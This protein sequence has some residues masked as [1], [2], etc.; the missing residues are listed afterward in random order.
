MSI[1]MAGLAVITDC[2]GA[3]IENNDQYAKHTSTHTGFHT[4]CG[5]QYVYVYVCI[6]IYVYVYVCVYV[7]VYEYMYVCMRV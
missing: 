6:R 5:L 4:I 7:Y 3:W 2:L 1:S